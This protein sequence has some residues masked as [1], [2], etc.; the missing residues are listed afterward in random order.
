[1]V[2]LGL[3]ACGLI[4]LLY[5]KL[6]LIDYRVSIR[7]GLRLFQRNDDAR[8]CGYKRIGLGFAFNC[9]SLVH[10]RAMAAAL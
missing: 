4:D 1:V 10:H 9:L 3:Y 7:L 8:A 6:P 2:I 5:A